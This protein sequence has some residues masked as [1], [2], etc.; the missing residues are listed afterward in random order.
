MNS[1]YPDSTC[2]LK[3]LNLKRVFWRTF[4]NPTLSFA[5][6]QKKNPATGAS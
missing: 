1:K 3:E 4:N 5:S 2:R 6:E